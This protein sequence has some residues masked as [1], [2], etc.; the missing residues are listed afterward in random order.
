MSKSQST[1]V[2][3]IRRSPAATDGSL[4]PAAAYEAQVLSVI[5]HRLHDLITD[6]SAFALLLLGSRTPEATAARM[7]AA[8]PI[9]EPYDELIGPFFDTVGLATLRGLSRQAIHAQMRRRHLLGVHTTDGDLL[10]PS[11]Q[12]TAAGDPLPHLREVLDIL[13]PDAADAWGDALWLN[14]AVD[15][16]G[17]RNAAQLL[18]QGDVEPVISA[19]THDAGQWAR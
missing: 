5:Q 4:N 3:G 7:L 2:N 6:D 13:D 8:L 16:F 18:R 12:F 14:A 19:A 11:F 1:Q 9:A 17:G 15:R 10:Y